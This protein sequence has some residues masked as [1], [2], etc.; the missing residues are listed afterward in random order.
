MTPAA[1][2]RVARLSA[3]CS[4]RAL[5][6]RRRGSRRRRAASPAAAMR[7]ASPTASAAPS[8]AAAGVAGS[9]S[10]STSRPL[11]VAR[12]VFYLMAAPNFLY[13]QYVQ[14]VVLKAPG[15]TPLPAATAFGRDSV[16]LTF[17]ANLHC[18]WYASLCLMYAVLQ[19]G[20]RVRSRPARAV[21]RVVHR[22]TT[23]LFPL[24]AFVGLAYYLILHFH[25]MNR[26]RAVLV[27]DHD[28]KMALLHLNP[29]LFALGDSLLKDADLL[30]KY[31]IKQRRA[32]L[33]V[34]V[35]GMCYFFWT[36]LCTRYNG[37]YW[38][39]P[40][41]HRFSPVHHLFFVAFSL[42]C[43]TYLTRSGFRL[44]ARLDRRR[45]RRCALSDNDRSSSCCTK[46]QTA[47][48]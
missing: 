44:H 13:A 47:V 19:L 4:L 14:L 46:Y 8:A 2:A 5:A 45:R 10:D 12:L 40:F 16:F 37:G 35:Y 26:L 27:P 43:A 28:A 29:L 36:L 21:E 48:S 25:P 6:C 3:S 11:R 1:V 9:A 15:R 31:A 34:N 38:P 22:F 24:A 33:F 42:T 39:Y 17:H 23:V 20:R 41:Q 30:A 18:T 32:V 7:C